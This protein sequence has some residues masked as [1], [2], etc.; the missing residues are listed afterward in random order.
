MRSSER[1]EGSEGRLRH[2]SQHK[3]GS[4]HLA[5]KQ[6]RYRQRSRKPLPRVKG[7]L[8]VV[9]ALVEMAGADRRIVFSLPFLATAICAI[10][11]K[12]PCSRDHYGT[13][14]GE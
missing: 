3:R 8:K 14:L 1:Q 9:H 4:A 7:Y 10:A 6:V 5:A 12:R 13:W 2:S 11:R